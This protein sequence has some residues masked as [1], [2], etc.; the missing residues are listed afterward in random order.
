MAMLRHIDDYCLPTTVTLLY[1]VRTNDDIIFRSELEEL[2]ARLNNF[3]YHILLSQPPAEWDGP[4]GRLNREFVESTIK[5]DASNYFFIC[6]PGPFMDAACQILSSLDVAPEKIIQESFG[7]PPPSGSPQ[8]PAITETATTVEFVRSKKTHSACQGQ[9]LLQAAEQC[10]VNIP[11]GCRQGQCGTCKVKLLDGVVSM[12]V[13]QGLSHDLKGQGYV[14]TCVGH[15]KG[16]VKLD[17]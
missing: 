14:L 4:K 2:R 6:G 5:E 7:S 17:A 1:S 8:D 9:T 13:E 11:S 12:D 16:Q 10:G 3:Q 15:A